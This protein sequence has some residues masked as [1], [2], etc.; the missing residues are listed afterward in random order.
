MVAMGVQKLRPSALQVLVDTK[1]RYRAETERGMLRHGRRDA[2]RRYKTWDAGPVIPNSVVMDIWDDKPFK[3]L[4]K[5]RPGEIV[6][7]QG[8]EHEDWKRMLFLLNKFVKA[9]IKG[10]ERR[11]IVDECLDFTSGTPSASTLKMTCSIGRL[12]QEGNEVLDWTSTPIEYMD[13]HPS[14][15]PWLPASISFICAWTLT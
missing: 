6:I 9:Q 15:L 5:D 8:A 10:V 7:M 11:I 2:S 13:C 3:D 14:F 12:V 4:W 1:P